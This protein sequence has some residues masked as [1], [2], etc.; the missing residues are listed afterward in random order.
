MT[1]TAIKVERLSK[2]YRIGLKEEMHDT[3]IGVL[4][5]WVKSPLSNFKRLRKL[6]HFDDQSPS[7]IDSNGQSS[8]PNNGQPI[9][10][11]LP[12]EIHGSD[13]RAHFIGADNP[14]Q[15][16]DIIWAVKDVSFEVKRGEVLGIIGK[17]GAGKS[18]LLKLLCRIVEPTSGDAFINGRVASLLEVGTGFHG[19]LTG[20]ENVFLNG[21]ILGM[22]KN[23]VEKKFDE[24][25][26]FSGIG[27]FIDTP[28]KRYSSGMSVRL[29]FAVAAHLEPEI[30]LID[31]VLAVGDAEFQKKCSGKMGD[32][33][34]EGRTVLLVSHN[35][36]VVQHLCNRAILLDKGHLMMEDLAIPV[37]QTY[38]EGKT[39]LSGERLW[40]DIDITSG[41]DVVRIHA[42][43]IKNHDG[44]ICTH[45]DVR[46]PVYLEIEYRILK[47]GVEIFT[48]LFLYDGK[49]RM[50]IV[51][52][53]NLDSPWRDSGSPRGLFR[54]VCCIPGDFLNEGLIT[55]G[56]ALA[57]R[58]TARPHAV[59]H[60]GPTFYVSDKLDPGGVRGNW[61]WKWHDAAVRVR[62]HWTVEHIPFETGS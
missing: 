47:E 45:F 59:C 61:P 24:I 29:A 49:G 9:T 33:A 1:D 57:S 8:N 22:T 13:S 5:S 31:E 32:V 38:L 51:T 40:R 48:E 10:N 39:D 18:T 35:M 16:D 6:S 17:N 2:R 44:Q 26:D 12:H 41:Y 34:K 43:R 15:S 62:L 53:D 19:E 36:E 56:Y 21:T 42:L 28:V 3:F 23:E 46:E 50:I 4:T 58:I 20:R 37:I 27:K 30:L 7:S 60:D 14:S 25:V 55:L 11:N 54:A 52:K